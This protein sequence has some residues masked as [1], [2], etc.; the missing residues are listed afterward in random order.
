MSN[1]GQFLAKSRMGLGMKKSSDK[2]NGRP[3]I[4][5]MNQIQKKQ[6]QVRNLR[7]LVL[8][9]AN[10]L[11]AANKAKMASRSALLLGA[12]RQRDWSQAGQHC[13]TL[14]RLIEIQVEAERIL[15]KHS[16]RLPIK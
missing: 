4:G 9:T 13:A 8:E 10:R 7:R 16:R 12:I 15:A 3:V 5:R 14:G 11:I 1:W 6:K 2:S